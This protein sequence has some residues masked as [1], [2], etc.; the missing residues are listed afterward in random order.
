MLKKVCSHC[1]EEY[2]PNEHERKLLNLAYGDKLYKGAGCNF[3]NDTGYRGRTAIH[4]VMNINAEVREL[5][6]SGGR[7]DQL[8]NLARSQGMTTLRESCIELVLSGI[9]TV[10]ELLRMTIQVS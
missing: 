2:D 4:E 9:T 3:C 1:K 5:I 7:T 10:D 8:R 6:D